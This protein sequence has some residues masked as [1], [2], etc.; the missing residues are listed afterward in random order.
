MHDGLLSY[1]S[2]GYPVLLYHFHQMYFAIQPLRE[3][4][5][6]ELPNDLVCTSQL[7]KV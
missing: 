6:V 3:H 7:E 2:V 4:F 1:I 5:V